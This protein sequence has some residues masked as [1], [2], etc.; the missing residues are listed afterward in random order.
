MNLNVVAFACFGPGVSVK[1]SGYV[2]GVCVQGAGE[3]EWLF[4]LLEGF[5][6]R[7]AGGASNLYA[8]GRYLAIKL[9]NV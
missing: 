5:W 4:D 7:E 6:L 2:V 9:C 1:A 8:D 3:G